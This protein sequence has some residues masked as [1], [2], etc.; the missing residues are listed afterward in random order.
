MNPELTKIIEDYLNGDLSANDKLAFE[1]KMAENEKLRSEVDFHR[2]IHEAA[3]RLALKSTIS[4]TAKNYHL[5]RN[6]IISG[7]VI[8]TLAIATGIFYVVKNT[9]SNVEIPVEQQRELEQV[10]DAQAPIDLLPT[11]YFQWQGNDTVFRSPKGV[12]ISVPKGAFLQNGKPYEKP[13]LVQYQ[14]AIDVQDIVKSGLSTMSGD[15]L[16]ETQGMFGLQA[17]TTDK[18]RLDVNPKI[19]VYMQVPVDE[20]KKGMMLFEGVKSK[21]GVIDWQNPQKLQK[22]PTLADMNDLDFYP[23]NYEK[24]LNEL[25]M[26]TD[27]KF[28]D[29]VYLSLEEFGGNTTEIQKEETGKNLFVSKCSVCHSLGKNSTGPN[30]AG[31]RQKWREIDETGQLLYSWMKDADKTTTNSKGNQ[32]A[33]IH[34]VNQFSPTATKHSFVSKNEID[35]ILD[36][37]DNSKK[38]SPLARKLT[39]DE[40]MLIYKRNVPI[41]KNMTL[42]EA[43]WLEML[44]GKKYTNGIQKE[45]TKIFTDSSIVIYE[46]S[47]AEEIDCKFLPPS[48]VLAFWKPTFNN[49]NL[50]TRDFERRMQAIHATCD[51]AVLKLYTTNLNL[52]LSEIDAKVVKMGYPQFQR[53]ADEQ[54]GKLDVSNAHLLNLQQFYDKS[55]EALRKSAAEITANRKKN[56]KAWDYKTNEVRQQESERS[57]ERNSKNLREEMELNTES[58]YRQLGK[59]RPELGPSV[60][61]TITSNVAVYNI[62]RFVVEQTISRT[63]GK[64]ID[65]G[66]GNSAKLTYEKMKLQVE[67]QTSFA[68]AFVY[69]FPNKLSSYHRITPTNGCFE[70]TL[71]QEFSY[72][73]A[74]VAY[75]DDGYYFYSKKFITATDLGT[76]KLESISE[77]KLN[78]TLASMNSSKAIKSDDISQEIAWLLRE[79]ADYVVQKKRKLDWQLRMKLAEVCFPCMGFGSEMEEPNEVDEIAF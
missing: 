22:L 47:I 33:F 1:Q 46:S 16:L 55:R 76:I 69:L 78:A 19:G 41:D 70:Y 62:D 29:S 39:P 40:S 34:T 11:Q 17:F 65:I 58:V 5:L 75:K 27:K 79:K 43:L 77:T 73:L 35:K 28:R 44:T 56:E 15:Q 60:G 13:I 48:N 68:R 10:F 6:L 30:L 72:D 45:E 51:P 42:E 25:K 20:A 67:N 54:I 32:V 50:S 64:I 21:E 49:T 36:F 57:T 74:I 38:P 9:D 18:K 23:P 59:K 7:A 26:K 71:N 61:F 14:E 52:P 63:S 8:L 2:N 37:V 4:S 12:L 31:V 3:K 53:F 24:T 66:T